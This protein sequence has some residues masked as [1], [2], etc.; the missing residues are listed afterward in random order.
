VET[1]SETLVS[2]PEAEAEP[3]A[4]TRRAWAFPSLGRFKLQTKLIVP[5][6]IL[7]VLVALIGTFVVTRL[8]AA[9]VQE[10]LANQL[11]EASRVAGDGVVRRERAHL[12]TL[13]LMAF[14]QGVPQALTAEDAKAL[15]DLLWPLAL[16]NNVEAV[17]AVNMKGQEVITLARDPA[18]GQYLISHGGDFSDFD[19][20]GK[21]LRSQSDTVG[22]KFVGLW[23]AR[24]GHY[25]FTTAPVRDSD[26]KLVGALM[27]GTRL[28]TLLNDLKSQSSA[29]GVIVLDPNGKL[30]A[31]TILQ[32]DEG[33]AAL[34]LETQAIS[35]LLGSSTQK[36]SLTRDLTLNQRSY[37]ALY[38]PLIVRQQTMGALGV[39]FDSNYVVAT[40][41]TS[42][43]Q[44]SLVF[45]LGTAFVVLIGYLLA[46]SIA[47]PI[48]RLRTISQAVAAG[49]LTQR[50]GLAPGDEIGE[51]ATAFDTMTLRLRQ[52]TAELVQSEK[53]AAVGQL[54]A[55]IV[56][57]VK[58][59]LAVIKGL[60]EELREELGSD[61]VVLE[62][63]NA[64]RD[65]ATRA[66][67]IVS[68]LMKF[69]RQSTPE[70]TRRDLR[71]TV[72]ASLRLTEYLARRAKVK[73]IPDLPA[74]SVLVT[75]D[76]QQ[77]EQVL[78][79][80]IQ[81]AIQAMPNGGTLRVN[82]SQTETTVAIAVQDTGTGIA[83]ENLPRVFDPFFTTK[84][85]GE[86]TGLGLS[87][88]YGIVARH[89]GRI[90]VESQVGEGTTFTILLPVEQPEFTERAT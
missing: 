14:T 50:T 63:L 61:P 72:E 35:D 47:G 69:A 54:T 64:I 58:N 6:V 51:L 78:I 27:I 5:Y 87:V 19:P 52:R 39:T 16:N 89:G 56:H 11:Y 70:M 48:L 76:A 68:D 3:P 45:A 82:L 36:S 86:G 25:L 57:D 90:N 29:H 15:Q 66:N 26:G 88:S 10:R 33:Y 60:S 23:E 32:P 53:L 38:A 85:E 37:R 13:R 42:R 80:L 20:I 46:R 1:S 43:N 71:E 79:N 30:V 22:D 34:E 40:E 44:L 24:F 9:S 83:A 8:V 59:P 55:G 77:L 73:Y 28:E 74:H 31:T 7:T 41:A 21:V 17:S 62:Q 75:Y 81:N 12:E 84:P 2:L 4:P 67:T 18:S 65:N 49:D